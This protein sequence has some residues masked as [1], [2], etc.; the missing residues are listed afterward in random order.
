MLGHRTPMLA[1]ERC[2]KCHL[3]MGPARSVA[4]GGQVVWLGDRRNMT[5]CGSEKCEIRHM[6]LRVMGW[7]VRAGY[8]FAC[9]ECDKDLFVL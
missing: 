3:V 5:H 8:Y 1:A 6:D 7:L 4:R 9:V 2:E